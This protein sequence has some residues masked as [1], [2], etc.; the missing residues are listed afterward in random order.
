MY[1]EDEFEANSPVMYWH[2]I[3]IGSNLCQ[4]MSISCQSVIHRPSNLGTALCRMVSSL[5]RRT[6][7]GQSTSNGQSRVVTHHSTNLASIHANL[8]IQSQSVNG[9]QLI[10]VDQVHHQRRRAT[11]EPN[12]CL[13]F[14]DQFSNLSIL[15]Q[16]M[17]IKCRSSAKPSANIPL[18]PKTHIC[19]SLPTLASTF[20]SLA[21]QCQP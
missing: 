13:F 10:L 7:S 17:S 19:Q 2:G 21:I 4:S 9:G 11:A 12:A 20:Q 14:Y 6:K 8:P 1:S 18:A 5:P 15:G 16:S 3:G